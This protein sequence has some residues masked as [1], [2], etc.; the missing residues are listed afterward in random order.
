VSMVV[1]LWIIGGIL[2]L[3]LVLLLLRV[4]VVVTYEEALT[5]TARLGPAHIQLVPGK[6]SEEKK[7]KKEKD[8]ATGEKNEKKSKKEKKAGKVP[9]PKPS[10]QEI[11]HTLPF[12]WGILKKTLRRTRKRILISPLQLSVIFGGDDP[13]KI[14]RYYGAAG[15]AVWTIMPQLEELMHIRDPHIHLGV[16]F[17]KERT[18]ASGSIGFSF[19]ILD[20]M[21]IG[22]GAGIPALKWYRRFEK[23]QKTAKKPAENVQK[24]PSGDNNNAEKIA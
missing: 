16:D 7:K 13:A 18:Q 10:W 12:F 2:A 1:A 15:T 9:F 20:L 6:E 5:V 22:L 3:L 11:K 8:K 4:G 24:D 19:L 21:V 14:S 23:E 17:N